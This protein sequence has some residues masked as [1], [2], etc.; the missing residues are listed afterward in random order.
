LVAAVPDS[1]LRILPG[2]GH[3]VMQED[4]DALHRLIEELAGLPSNP[5]TL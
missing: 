5:K 2:I 4:P 3:Q 1:Q